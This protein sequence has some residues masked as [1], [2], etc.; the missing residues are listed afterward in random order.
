[1]G[2]LI[3]ALHLYANSSNASRQEEAELR[4]KTARLMG[5]QSL[6]RY[7]NWKGDA[8]AIAAE[9]DIPISCY[10]YLLRLTLRYRY[11]KNKELGLKLGSWKS[12]QLV[13]DDGGEVEQALKEL[14]K[15]SDAGE[16][17]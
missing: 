17:K 11:A 9:Y 2:A 8:T 16:A 6:V 14:E 10:C 7:K 5:R 3:T 1:M 13:A 12:G 4:V 15:Q